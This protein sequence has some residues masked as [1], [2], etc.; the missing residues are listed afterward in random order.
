MAFDKN[1]NLVGGLKGSFL[2]Q[3][4]TQTRIRSMRGPEMDKL[5]EELQASNPKEKESEETSALMEEMLSRLDP[6][7]L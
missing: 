4:A 6:K 1:N 3:R 5:K 2:G 7:N